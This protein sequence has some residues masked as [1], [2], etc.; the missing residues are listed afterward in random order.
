MITKLY[1]VM[2][3]EMLQKLKV[4]LHVFYSCYV[5]IYF[6]YIF[7]V[8]VICLIIYFLYIYMY[9]TCFLNFVILYFHII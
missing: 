2:V 5:K 4:L 3:A 6:C 7:H 9:V 1:L 8:Y